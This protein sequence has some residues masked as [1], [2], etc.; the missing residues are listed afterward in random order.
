MAC[1][2]GSEN[3]LLEHVMGKRCLADRKG[4]GERF[5]SFAIISVTLCEHR[6]CHEVGWVSIA[7]QST[8]NHVNYTA[9]NSRYDLASE[10]AK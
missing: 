6:T 5:D 7:Q 8:S 3:T 10:C 1:K 9:M 4:N 2:M